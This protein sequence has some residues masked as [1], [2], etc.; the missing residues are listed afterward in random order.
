MK[1]IL[2]L[3]GGGIRGILPAAILAHLEERLQTI[4]S[5]E[6]FRLAECFD[7]LAGTSTG[8]IITCLYL[9]PA[10]TGSLKPKYSAKQVLDFYVELGPVLFHRSLN[11]LLKSGLGVFRSRYSEDALYDFSKRLMGDHYISEV[12]KDCLVTAY[13]L[14]TRKA[15]LFSKKNVSKYGTMADYKLCDVVRSTSAAPSYFS[16]ARIFARDNSSR[17]LVDGGVYANNPTMCALVEAVKLWPDEGISNYIM[18]SVGTGKVIKPYFWEKTHK[19]GYLN[20]LEPIID[21]LTASVAETVD[22][23]LQQLFSAS[24]VPER[25][26]RVEPPLLTADTRMDNASAKNIRALQNAAQYYIDHNSDTFDHLIAWV[27][28]EV[29]GVHISK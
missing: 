23:Q 10:E 4:K 6:S 29:T 2:S 18:V 14:S 25:Y 7:L 22:F 28:G 13:D 17:H 11:Q 26:I 8:G 16:P 15:L 9:T 19:Y 3:D 12:L 27:H 24:G 1:K 21:I 20:W 5:D